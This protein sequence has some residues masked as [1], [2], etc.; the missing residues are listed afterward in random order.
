MELSEVARRY[1]SAKKRFLREIENI[2]EEYVLSKYKFKKGD[3]VRFKNLFYKPTLVVVDSI[4]LLT[5]QKFL[6]YRSIMGSCVSIN[7]HI[8]DEG[9][10]NIPYFVGGNQC[11]SVKFEAKDVFEVT[12]IIYKD[13]F[14]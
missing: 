1:E 8:V 4:C 14:R 10:Y 2:E 7:G 3:I 13:Q 5:N 11:I 12:N 6:E 9:G